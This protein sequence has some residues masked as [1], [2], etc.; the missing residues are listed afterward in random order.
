MEYLS[1]MGALYREFS[2]RDVCCYLEVVE[3]NPQG[4]VA[5]MRSRCNQWKVVVFFSLHW[6]PVCVDVTLGPRGSSSFPGNYRGTWPV[7]AGF[8]RA[9]KFT[10]LTREGSTG[11]CLLW[12][13]V[14]DSN[15]MSCYHESQNSNL[16]FLRET[17]RDGQPNFLCNKLYKIF[18]A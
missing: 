8:G 3:N 5:I 11:F 14:W 13:N 12:C 2:T 17:G 18:V 4:H 7:F 15:G 6:L 9:C 1:R 16:I 10:R